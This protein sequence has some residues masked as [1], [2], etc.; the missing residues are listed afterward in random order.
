MKRLTIDLYTLIIGAAFLPIALTAQTSTWNGASSSTDNWSDADNWG[1]I[2]PSINDVLEFGQSTRLTPNNDYTANTQFSGINFLS[3]AGAFTLTGNAINLNGDINSANENT[4]TINM[5]IALLKDIKVHLSANN[6]SSTINLDGNISG[7]YGINF[8]GS[9]T[10]G[11]N[12]I[13]L[14]GNNSY[15]GTSTIGSEDNRVTVWCN[16]QDSLPG[17]VTV[18][19]GS[20]L[21]LS[22]D[23]FT[24]NFNI[25]G[26]GART[27]GRASWA[28][29]DYAGALALNDDANISGTVTLTGN[30]RISGNYNSSG[31]ISGQITGDYDLQFGFV[32]ERPGSITLKN[33]NNNWKG[34]TYITGGAATVSSGRQFKLYLGADNVLPFGSGAGDIY[35]GTHNTVVKTQGKTIN[36]NGLN[37]YRNDS[38][39][40]INGGGSFILGHNNAD[41]QFNGTISVNT[42]TKVGTGTQSMGGSTVATISTTVSN[43]TLRI[44]GGYLNGGMIIVHD[45]ATLEIDGGELQYNSAT[46]MNLDNS[47]I[48]AFTSGTL[49]GTNWYGGAQ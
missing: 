3:T 7:P 2:I 23:I 39:G 33:T 16:K 12:Q 45:E 13:N 4:Q 41:G 27:L 44:D 25:S 6:A 47:G 26:N 14:T 32:Q 15:T 17:D 28:A 36:I 24:N 10:Y 18:V 35:I 29:D 1:G 46:P 31:F 22:S 9:D 42:L 40:T 21:R 19:D 11:N 37:N 20:T 34:N 49:T 30:S 43:G 5:N 8:S 48:F 38:F